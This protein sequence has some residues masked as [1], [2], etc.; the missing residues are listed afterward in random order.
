ML[1]LISALAFCLAATATTPQGEALQT[2]EQADP[3]VQEDVALVS[4]VGSV[5]S[6]RRRYYAEGAAHPT[7]GCSINA[8]TEGKDP[9]PAGLT[10]LFE[11]RAVLL[12]LVYAW[13]VMNELEE[14]WPRDLDDLMASL[15]PSCAADWQSLPSAFAIMDLRGSYAV[16][17]FNLQHGCEAARGFTM[18]FDILIEIPADREQWFREAKSAGHLGMADSCG[19]SHEWSCCLR[20]EK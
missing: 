19:G 9:R 7:Y 3:Q 4:R 16:V 17:R 13:P 1:K 14:H 6:Y 18:E 12:A 5:A 11:E 8:T 20:W 10:D 2:L 15:R